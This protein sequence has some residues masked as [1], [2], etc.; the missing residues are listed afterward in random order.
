MTV[1]TDPP[2]TPAAPGPAPAGGAPLALRMAGI[3]KSFG[4]TRALVD[5]DLDV[6]PGEVHAL[7]GENGAGKSTLMKVLSG[8]IQPDAGR[9]VLR[10][11]VYAPRGP[12]EARSRGVAMIYQELSLAPD[13][14]VEENVLLGVEPVRLGFVRR[15]EM[16]RKVE[17]AL[18]LLRHPDIHPAAR[19]GDLSIG[20][21]Q[22]VEVARALAAKARVVVMDE[23][24]SSLT[25]SDTEVLFDVIRRLRASGV[26]VI[27]ISHFLEEV[28]AVADRFS[29]LR[30][31]RSVGT[32]NVATTPTSQIIRLMVGRDL[33]DVY[34]RTPH[35]VGEP[36][37]DLA[38]LTGT[39]MPRGADLELR[40]G[41]VLGIAGLIGSG[42]TELIRA[43]FG[44]DAIAAG[45]VRVAGVSTTG[46]GPP[47]MLRRG[48]GFLSEDR[49][50]EGLAENL[51]V[52]DNMVL[53]RL[54]PYV[55]CG[56]LSRNR[57]REAA[58]HWIGRLGI[59]TQGPDQ[60]ITGLSGGNQ[61]K[62]ALARLLHQEAEVLLLDEPTRGIDVGSK[63][64]IYALIGELAAQGKAILW[65]SSYLPE[66]LG[67][68]D[69]L[70]VMHRGLLSEKRPVA[71]W[72]PEAIMRVATGGDA[73]AAG[74]KEAGG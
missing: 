68:C 49:K 26:S 71:A 10:G 24:T 12:L 46:W 52:A 13:L 62:V 66:L 9:M 19:A 51:S 65:I 72:S 29:V 25:Q 27:Y 56:L 60:P 42:R 53:S 22:L 23:P 35:E 55:S 63:A 14:S 43:V 17:E 41:E 15:R 36:V 38:A 18:A 70:A 4:S 39:K 59:R 8:A 45:E 2:T 34:K 21:Q 20:A 54:G 5:V 3:S 37:L 64:D 33:S 7:V 61:Q 31:G 69:S 1:P 74:D 28:R 11:E 40:R 16:R 50:T 48:V 73:D 30:D 44:L 47:R 58:M 57:M 32:G 67:V 6:R